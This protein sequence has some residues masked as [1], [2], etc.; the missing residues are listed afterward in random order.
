MATIIRGPFFLLQSTCHL[1][2]FVWRSESHN[3]IYQPQTLTTPGAVKHPPF[4]CSC[5]VFRGP[6]SGACQ[7]RTCYLGAKRK[8]EGGEGPFVS[9]EF[10][11][12]ALF[13][14]S[15][16]HFSISHFLSFAQI[17]AINQVHVLK[18]RGAGEGKKER[19]GGGGVP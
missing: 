6:Q 18:R 3:H 17:T 13:P 1:C 10:I 8:G 9:S 11:I 7:P 14:I 16:L 5:N 12:S 4:V 15:L 19:V 2:L